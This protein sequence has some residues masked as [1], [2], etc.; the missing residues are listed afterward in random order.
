MSL[1]L[2]KFSDELGN[3]FRIENNN[4]KYLVRDEFGSD[5]KVEKYFDFLSDAEEYS[6]RLKRGLFLWHDQQKQR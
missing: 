6:K 1:I 5:I 4:G 3:N 2:S